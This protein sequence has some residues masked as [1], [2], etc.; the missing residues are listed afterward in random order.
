M[1]TRALAQNTYSKKPPLKSLSTCQTSLSTTN[2]TVIEISNKIVQFGL[3]PL[4][5][6]SKLVP[7]FE[8]TW[9]TENY[10]AL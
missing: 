6:A 9:S 5:I 7:F 10:P 1:T 8:K 4:E 2:P 3:E